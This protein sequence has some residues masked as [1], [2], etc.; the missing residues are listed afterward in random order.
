LV[1]AVIET[2]KPEA[3]LVI[4]QQAVQIDQ[5]GR[6]VLKVGDDNKVQVQR[7]TVGAEQEGCYV[8]TNGLEQ[9]EQ[10]ITEGLQK[11]LH[12]ELT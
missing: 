2:A 5:A 4:P 11:V 9:G 3:A 12:P 6:Y 1:T 7:I 10:V 8:V